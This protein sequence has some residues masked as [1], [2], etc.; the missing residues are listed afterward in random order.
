[1]NRPSPAG[2]TAFRRTCN[3]RVL[4]TARGPAV[5]RQAR[6]GRRAAIGGSGVGDRRVDGRIDSGVVSRTVSVAIGGA[7]RGGAVGLTHGSRRARPRRAPNESVLAMSVL[8]IPPPAVYRASWSSAPVAP[9][10]VG[11]RGEAD[12]REEHL[13][14]LTCVENPANAVAMGHEPS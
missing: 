11:R 1:H 6:V 10:H 8:M 4:K 3:T 2:R 14:L 12:R 5:A 7:H 13:G 9:H